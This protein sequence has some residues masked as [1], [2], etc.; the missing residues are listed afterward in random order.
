MKRTSLFKGLMAMVFAL[1]FGL[2]CFTFAGCGKKYTGTSHVNV[3]MASATIPPM[4]AMLDTIDTEDD[5][6]IWVGRQNT[7]YSKENL[8]AVY[9]EGSFYEK[10][11]TASNIPAS[12][13][14]HMA[15]IVSKC[16]YDSNGRVSFDIYV[17][18][19]GVLSGLY[20]VNS[21]RVPENK[22]KIHLL[23]DGSGAYSQYNDTGYK[24]AETGKAAYDADKAELDAAIKKMKKG[25]Y[26]AKQDFKSGY[27]LVYAATTLPSVDYYLQCPNFITSENE[28]IQAMLT[29]KTFDLKKKHQ[30][31]MY[32]ALSAESKTKFKNIILNPDLDEAMTPEEGK[33][34]LMITGT[35]FT[36][37]GN[38]AIATEGENAWGKGCTFEQY[39]EYLVAKYGDTHTIVYKGHPSW[40]LLENEVNT[41]RWNDAEKLPNGLT[42]AQGLNCAAR[43]KA[44]FDELGIRVVPAQ[45]PAEA[46]IWAYG[47]VMDLCGYDSSLYFNAPQGGVL[48]VLH[49]GSYGFS[50]INIQLFGVDGALYNEDL[51]VLTLDY[52][53][54]HPIEP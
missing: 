5:T 20:L 49:N 45:T 17:T 28:E 32:N 29:N 30:T 26:D 36:G 13:V 9:G 37:E 2:S 54:A 12:V 48:C 31:E 15:A 23:E 19:Y 24:N 18:D 42:A 39:V 14:A 34:I 46:F 50:G 51:Y 47:D 27:G 53:A 52:I 44:F 6:Y 38:G 4:Q 22:Y 16:W 41:S 8:E 25:K 10:W 43:R 11:S 1:V 3:V 7:I 33:R 21:I 35:A 40:G